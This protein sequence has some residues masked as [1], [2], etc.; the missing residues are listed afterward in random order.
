MSRSLCLSAI[1]PVNHR[2]FRALVALTSFGL[3]ASCTSVTVDDDC[4]RPVAVSSSGVYCGVRTE[5]SPWAPA[6]AYWSGATFQSEAGHAASHDITITFDIPVSSIE[7]TA[8]DPTFAG[9]AMRA[10]DA[11]GRLVGSADF[12]GNGTPRSLTT[13]VRTIPGPIA[14]VTLVPAANDYL[15]YSM[16]VQYRG[17]R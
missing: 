8:Y 11:E 17:S 12:P 3:G 4:T 7:V 15:N 2:V 9:N 16:R 5:I 14:S 1:A 13:Q 10:Y 6:D